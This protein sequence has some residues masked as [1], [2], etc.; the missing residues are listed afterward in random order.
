MGFYT[1]QGEH[2]EDNIDNDD[3]IEHFD[4]DPTETEKL[5]SIKNKS[6]PGGSY[7]SKDNNCTKCSFDNITKILK[8]NCK[9]KDKDIESS[10]NY[11]NC[12]DQFYET[13]QDYWMKYTNKGSLQCVNNKKDIDYWDHCKNCQI[14]KG[15]KG[16]EFI[17]CTCYGKTVTTKHLCD[18]QLE[19][20]CKNCVDVKNGKLLCR[21]KFY[22]ESP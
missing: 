21:N 4:F 12:M 8:C 11:N 22:N 18:T 10:I 20:A 5:P 3:I 17:K 1:A 9:K 7:L 15:P 6:L 19:V 2:I 16:N 13:S 14:L